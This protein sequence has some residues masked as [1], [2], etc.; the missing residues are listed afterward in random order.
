MKGAPMD[1]KSLTIGELE[2]LSKYLGGTSASHNIPVGKPVYVRTV[3]HH[4]TGFVERV[5]DYDIVLTQ[6]AW[7]ADDGPFSE[8]LAKG[9]FAEVEPYPDGEVLIARA[10]VLDISEWRHPLPRERK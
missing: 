4:Y 8:A 5:S 1:Y 7:I 10:C 2:Q 9:T 6:A 3:T